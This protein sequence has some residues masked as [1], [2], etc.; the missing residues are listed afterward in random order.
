MNTKT[1]HKVLTTLMF[2]IIMVAS[3]PILAADN[4]S[5]K[6][7]GDQTIFTINYQNIPANGVK[8]TLQVWTDTSQACSFPNNIPNHSYDLNLTSANSSA[9]YDSTGLTQLIGPGQVCFDV[10]VVCPTIG[11]K[12]KIIPGGVFKTRLSDS[13]DYASVYSIYDLTSSY[14]NFDLSQCK[15]SSSATSL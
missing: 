11:N 14:A 6:Q 12:T 8:G 4:V 5:T 10:K 15:S 2:G 13:G 1:S 7:A 3:T 9:Q